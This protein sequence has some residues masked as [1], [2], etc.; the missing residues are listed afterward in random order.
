MSHKWWTEKRKSSA[1]R[2]F[3]WRLSL[4]STISE[5]CKPA[6]EGGMTDSFN[7]DS[8]PLLQLDH[9]LIFSWCFQ[10]FCPSDI[11]FMRMGG[12]PGGNFFIL[13]PTVSDCLHVF[14]CLN[15]RFL[16]ILQVELKTNISGLKVQIQFFL[17]GTHLYT[18]E[19]D[20]NVNRSFTLKPFNSQNA[21]WILLW[22]GLVTGNATCSSK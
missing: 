15:T 19:Q 11:T 8:A 14:R 18:N 21:G 22:R 4:S 6:W 10:V 9:F 7:Q 17:Q 20:A 2:G 1:L 13:A 5:A 16:G 3:L 12:T